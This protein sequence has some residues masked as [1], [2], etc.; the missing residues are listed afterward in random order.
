[1]NGENGLRSNWTND[2]LIV[3]EAAD[4]KVEPT[5]AKLIDKTVADPRDW[6]ESCES[7]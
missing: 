6:R 2:A 4:E 5:A 1:M 3:K 7:D